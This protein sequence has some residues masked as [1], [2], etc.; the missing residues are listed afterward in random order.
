MVNDLAG[1]R[2]IMSMNLP[3]SLNLNRPVKKFYKCI[4]EQKYTTKLNSKYWLE[5]NFKIPH[6]LYTL[7]L[8][9]Q[10]S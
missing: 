5:R 6:R 7:S 2:V 10:I 1:R 9:R 3:L 4:N 8:Y